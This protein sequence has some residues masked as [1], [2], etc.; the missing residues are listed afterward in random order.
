MDLVIDDEVWWQWRY[1]DEDDADY[2]SALALA[3]DLGQE[4][5]TGSQQ[6][7]QETDLYVK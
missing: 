3:L 6:Q 4:G 5:K 2:S 7:R 1:W